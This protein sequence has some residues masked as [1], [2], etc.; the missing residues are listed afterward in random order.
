MGP[1]NTTKVSQ[2]SGDTST[3]VDDSLEKFLVEFMER[4]EEICIPR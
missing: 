1:A 4:D 3:R 2:E